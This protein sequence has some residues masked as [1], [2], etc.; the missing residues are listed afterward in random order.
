MVSTLKGYHY[1]SLNNWQQIEQ[2]GLLPSP[3][4]YAQILATSPET[5]GSW[6]F[7]YQQ[8]GPA[9]FGQLIDL[10]ARQEQSWD[11]VELEVDFSIKDCLKALHEED[12]LSL[13]H[14]GACGPWVYHEDEPIIIVSKPIPACQIKLL[15]TFD[16]ERSIKF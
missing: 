8:D 9:L 3:F 5:E 7:R 14:D 12:T 10:F 4:D 16:L 2:E 1:T 6:L 15:R 13:T 11:Y